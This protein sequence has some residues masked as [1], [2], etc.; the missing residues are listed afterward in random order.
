MVIR[1]QNGTTN[2][3]S[4]VSYHCYP[5]EK[6][7][8]WSLKNDFSPAQKGI[9]YHYNRSKKKIV[10]YFE[11]GILGKN[12][13]QSFSKCYVIGYIIHVAGKDYMLCLSVIMPIV[14]Y[15][16]LVG[17]LL[18]LSLFP[19]LFYAVFVIWGIFFD[20]KKIYSFIFKARKQI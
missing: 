19:L 8:V 3:L 13:S 6:I 2:F 4:N 10:F 1:I 5:D 9:H 14:L 16:I 15:I 7:H 18:N 20:L 11:A 12:E 17:C